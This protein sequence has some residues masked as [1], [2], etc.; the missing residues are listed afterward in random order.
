M[1]SNLSRMCQKHTGIAP[2]GQRAEQD[3]RGTQAGAE[4]ER[5]DGA[6]KAGGAK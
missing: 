1:G 6:G 4:K 5:E 2:G 3:K